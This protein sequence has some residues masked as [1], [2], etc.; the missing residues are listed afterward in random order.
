[1]FVLS[2][3]C[4]RVSNKR[5]VFIG[6]KKAIV[7]I[8]FC[9]FIF[10]Q[11][12]YAKKIS[13]LT[14][15]LEAANIAVADGKLF[16]S[17]DNSIYIYSLKDTKLIKKVGK[18]GEGPNEFKSN[19]SL[20][21]KNN[22][23]YAYGERLHI[24]SLSGDFLRLIKLKRNVFDLDLI[25]KNYVLREMTSLPQKSGKPILVIRIGLYDKN[26]KL[27]KEFS[28]ID[29]KYMDKIELPPSRIMFAVLDN[30]IFVAD[31]RKGLYVDVYDSLGKKL[32]SI[33]KTYEKKIIPK[34]YIKKDLEKLKSKTPKNVWLLLK[35]K[36][37]YVKYFPAF[38]KFFVFD[39]KL[40]F[41]TYETKGDKVLFRILGPKGK[42]L[43]NV[44][45]PN[46][47][48]FTVKNGTYYYLKRNENDDWV[49]FSEKVF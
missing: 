43:K 15:L 17:A 24:L 11:S 39:G 18:K 2:G 31:A 42:E 25:D 35:D 21:V 38:D 7:F 1:V 46:S 19:P 14:D 36:Y 23:L 26:E 40:Y 16:V 32:Y 48:I 47:Q 12:I 9:L 6:W 10:T 33:N 5:K 22:K 27:I 37:V 49:L 29:H 34:E 41:K 13:E 8:L 20:W 4:F 45:L 3:D 44:F 30:K 28:R